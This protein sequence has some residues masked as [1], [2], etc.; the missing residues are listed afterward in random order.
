MQEVV[1]EVAR[2]GGLSLSLRAGL[3]TGPVVVGVIGRSRY[4]FD[5]WGAT[6]NA[7]ARLEAAG[8]C[9]RLHTNALAARSLG[10]LGVVA[11]GMIELKGLGP[12]Q[13]FWVELA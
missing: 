7:A 13:T 4:A 2:E 12:T 10:H 1:R 11:R 6:V 9:E 3:A 8:T 5:C